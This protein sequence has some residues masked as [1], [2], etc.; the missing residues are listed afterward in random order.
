VSSVKVVG[1]DEQMEDADDRRESSRYWSVKCCSWVSIDG[2]ETLGSGL[3]GKL[4][5]VSCNPM[6]DGLARQCRRRRNE[7]RL[8]KLG[9]APL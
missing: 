2:N 9:C 8:S 4:A 7:L 1:M 5:K 3:L 6:Q